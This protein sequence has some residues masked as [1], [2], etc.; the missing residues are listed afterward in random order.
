M[1]DE[2]ADAPCPCAPC[3][4]R[5]RAHSEQFILDHTPM[6]ST[7]GAEFASE[8]RRL[9]SIAPQHSFREQLA[10]LEEFN[11][12][13]EQQQWTLLL[14]YAEDHRV[15]VGEEFNAVTEELDEMKT[16]IEAAR[17][18]LDLPPAAPQGA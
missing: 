1:T 13:T 16:L 17:K 15:T 10:A 2:P 8:F 3:I 7:I 6:Q 14:R 11:T 12:A 18:H 5:Q 9:V 4:A